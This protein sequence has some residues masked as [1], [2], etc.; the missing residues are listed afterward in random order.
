MTDVVK[1]GLCAAGPVS[2]SVW[3]AGTEP[4]CGPVKVGGV[5]GE[6]LTELAEVMFRVIGMLVVLFSNPAEVMVIVPV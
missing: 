6:I 5:L 4:S 3:E 1:V 2:V